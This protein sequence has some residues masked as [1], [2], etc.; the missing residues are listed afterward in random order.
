M[1]R[2]RFLGACLAAVIA[3][4]VPVPV[5]AHEPEILK[6]TEAVFKVGDIFTMSEVK[7]KDGSLMQFKVTS[8]GQDKINMIPIDWQRA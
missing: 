8:I 4:Y 6:V 3:P 5:A 7:N 2:R 1:K